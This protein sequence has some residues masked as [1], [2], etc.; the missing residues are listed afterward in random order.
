MRTW[1][2]L[3]CHGRKDIREQFDRAHQACPAHLKRR[4]SI[5]AYKGSAGMVD[6]SVT[7]VRSCVPLESSGCEWRIQKDCSSEDR[8]GS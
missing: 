1:L 7:K 3:T 2:E 4:A 5:T 8:A 6:Y